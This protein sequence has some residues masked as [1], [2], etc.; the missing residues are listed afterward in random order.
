MSNITVRVLYA[1][2]AVL[3]VFFIRER[4]KR[5]T[6]KCVFLK[7]AVSLVFVSVAVLAVFS[8]NLTGLSGVMAVL[9]TVGLVSGLTGD[10]WL[11]LKF[12]FPDKDSAFTM[13][14]FICFGVEHILIIIGILVRFG[15]GMH[16]ILIVLAFGISTGVSLTNLSFEKKFGYNY[17][18]MKGAV[19][20]Y[21]IVI[22]SMLLTTGFL[23]LY[24]QKFVPA[25]VLIFTGAILFVF[26]DMILS[27]N[28]FKKGRNR[29]IDILLIHLSYYP[30][31]FLIATS[32]VFL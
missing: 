29:S 6:L 31:Q 1:V 11:D 13:A 16:P 19:A 28:Y 7:T 15:Q 25:L 26:S 32:L 3:F 18:S 4:L 9:I 24:T 20:G 23:N 10:I 22:F 27:G 2:A 21:G 14:G 5:C 17:D 12:V 8:E 30:A